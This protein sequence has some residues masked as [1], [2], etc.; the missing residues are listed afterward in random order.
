MLLIRSVSIPLSVMLALCASL[1]V[2]SC[3]I[4]S[5]CLV[6]LLSD[7]VLQLFWRRDY[8]ARYTREY[9]SLIEAVR[10][11]SESY[12]ADSTW[13]LSSPVGSNRTPWRW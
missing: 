6:I 2:A 1:S 8:T 13:P 9:F 7:S 4:S 10:L 12:R 3:T 5:L 11:P